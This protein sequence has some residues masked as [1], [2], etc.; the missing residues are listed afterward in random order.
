MFDVVSSGSYLLSF[1]PN[2]VDVIAIVAPTYS[3]ETNQLKC[4]L[5]VRLTV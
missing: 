1:F 3:V 5:F 2:Y 4:E